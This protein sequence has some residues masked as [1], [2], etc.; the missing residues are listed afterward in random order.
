MAP[1][2]KESIK[3]LERTIPENLRLVLDFDSGEYLVQADPTQIQQVLTNLAV[4]ARDAMPEGGPISFRCCRLTLEPGG[5]PPC[6]DMPPGHWIAVSVADTGTGIPPDILPRIFEPFLTTKGPGRGTGLGLA[7]VYGIVKQ[8]QGCIGVNTQQGD[9]TT[10]T[11]YLPALAVPEPVR[12]HTESEEVPIGH[13]E[14]LLLVE[15]EPIVLE[16]GKALLESLDYHVL[17]ASNGRHALEVYETH[18]DQ[19]AL[20]VADMVMPEMDGVALFQAFKAQ[21]SDVKMVMM[22]GYPSGEKVAELL[23]QGLADWLQKPVSRAQLASVVGRT[24]PSSREIPNPNFQLPN[25]FK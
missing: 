15:D 4:N 1:F 24:L 19:I 16:T 21:S 2:L 13:G 20:V 14:T 12:S 25:K 22:S 17:T 18:K 8:H 5:R 3:F 6:P 11:I 7:Q 23:A 9:G 10:F